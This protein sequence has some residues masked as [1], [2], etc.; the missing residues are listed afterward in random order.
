MTGGT[1]QRNFSYLCALLISAFLAAACGL[2]AGAQ[3]SGEASRRPGN[4]EASGKSME[5]RK[6]EGKLKAAT[7][8]AGCFWCVEA[9]FERLE[10]VED[11]VSGYCG[12]HVDN[13]TYE[14]VCTG[15]TGHAEA[16]RITYDP[17]RISYAELLE[18]FWKTHDPTTKDRQGND[19]GPQYR[20][21]IFYHDEEQRKLA[22]EYKARLEAERIWDRPIVTEIVPAG[23]FWP[24]ESYHQDYYARNPDKGYCALV[25]TP[26]IE[27]FRKIF[28]DRL[29]K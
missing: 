2:G 25:I 6:D 17:E 7:F 26:K 14:Q 9:V 15:T 29:K 16:C 1:P 28:R 20:S 27:K 13:P 5:D 21:V 23:R 22:Q 10:G 3:R 11:V 18:V 19:V 12:G 4:G 8:A 24:A